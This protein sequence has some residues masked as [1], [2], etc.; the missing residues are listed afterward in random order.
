MFEFFTST[1]LFFFSSREWAAIAFFLLIG[2][3]AVMTAPS[4]V[5]GVLKALLHPKL[6][7]IFFGGLVYLTFCV[8]LLNIA[9]VWSSS[10]L[11]ETIFYAIAST[12]LVT[13]SIQISKNKNLFRNQIWGNIKATT[14][15]AYVINIYSFPFWA[16]LLLL[17]IFSF[18]TIINGFAK[19]WDS[20]KYED[21]IK[22][23][24]GVIT[25]VMLVYLIG[26][27]H[28]LIDGWLDI[29]SKTNFYCLLLPI[30]L[31]IMFIPYMYA[32]ALYSSYELMLMRIRVIA[33]NT[34][35]DY[36]FRRN[37]I[38]KT[39]GLNI[40]KIIAFDKQFHQYGVDDD[41]DF[42]RYVKMAAENI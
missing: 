20:V 35:N 9:G 28:W 3:W 36:H 17:I 8:W 33:Q 15:I 37:L 22:F 34:G 27:I 42:A 41:A 5:A 18:F 32:I 10:L 2:L 24:N 13:K 30:V 7:G 1:I 11:K 26:F 25:L 29:F 40:N 38:L 23:S 4:A 39:C 16:E 12:A 19:V 6:L 31:G 21:A 14:I